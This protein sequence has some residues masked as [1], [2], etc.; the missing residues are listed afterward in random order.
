MQ[1]VALERK[2]KKKEK[3]KNTYSLDLTQ[4]QEYIGHLVRTELITNS[5]LKLAY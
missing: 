1:G 5:S 4:S 2:K 3:E